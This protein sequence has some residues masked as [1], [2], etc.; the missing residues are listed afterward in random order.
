MTSGSASSPYGELVGFLE[1]VGKDPSRLVFEDELT[2]IHNRRFLRSYLK[3]KVRWDSDKDFPLSLLMIDLDK[4]KEINDTHGHDTGDQVLTYMAALLKDVVGD[5]G[6][7]I[8]FGGDE[9]VLL[10]P[11]AKRS[12]AWEMA[13][14]LLQRTWDRPFRLRAGGIILPITMSIGVAA[15]PEDASDSRG[16]FQAADTAL[17]HAKQSGRNQAASAGAIDLT[18]VF[19]KTAL[20]RLI[21]SGIHGREEE[22]AAVS[23]ALQA[24]SQGQSQF[25]IVDGAPGMGKTAFLDTVR[26]N[27]TSNQALYIAKVV[28]DQKEAYRPYYLATR[29][30]VALLN[31]RK[32]KGTGIL[33]GLGSQEISYLS[34]ILPQLTEGETAPPAEDDSAT[35]QGIFATLAQFLPRIVDSR[36][37]VL[38]IDD[39]QFADEASLLL[40]RTLLQREG[41]ALFVCGSTLEFLKLSADQEAP[42]LER[43]YS[44]R[45]AELGIRRVKLKPLGGDDIAEYLRGVFPSLQMPDGFETDLA[46]LTQ[47]NPLFLGEI[48]RNLV[49][50]RKV[51]LV[52]QQWVIEPLEEGYLPRSLDEIVMQK[53]AALDEEGRQL[54]ERASTLGEDIPVSVLTGSSELDENKVLEFLDRA[55]ALGLISLDFDV[56]DETMRF[57]GKRVMEISYG[58][59]DEDRRKKLHE[60]VGSYQEGLYQQRILPSAS[61]L[62]Y[63]FKRSANQE[64]AR[65]Y[66]QIQLSYTKTVFNPQEAVEYTGDIIEEE[67]ETERRIEPESL[68]LVPNLLRTLMKAV[69]SIQLYPEESRGVV[70]SLEDLKQTVDEILEKNERLHLS[71]AQRV[72]LVNGQRLDVSEV[73]A[74]A[75]AFLELLNRYQ[76]QG[77]TFQQGLTDGEIK[78]LLPTLIKLKPETIDQGFWKTFAAEHGLEQ[79]ELQQMRY[80]RIVRRKVRASAVARAIA[81]EQEL[82]ADELAKIPNVLRAFQGA[83]KTVK[84]YPMGS[85]PVSRAVEQLHG[86]L[87]GILIRHQVLTLAGAE[88]TLLVN[89]ARVDTKGFDG[90]AANLLAFFHSV[91]LTSVTF[92]SNVTPQ[93][94]ETFAGALHA[95]PAAGSE[96][97]F[98]DSFAAEKG[99]TGLAFNQRKYAVGMVQSL[100]GSV[101]VELTEDAAEADAVVELAEQMPEEPADLWEALPR[102]GKELLV[103]GE[104]KLVHQLLQRLFEGYKDQDTPS[105]EQTMHACRALMDGLILGL[106][107]K[108]AELSVESL[109]KA[110]AEETEPQVLRELGALLYAMSGSAVQFANFQLASRMLLELKTRRQQL[111]DTGGR[112]ATSLAALLDRKLSPA[113][114]QLLVDDLSSG[115]P[116]RHQRAAQVI[117][118]LGPSSI[119]LLI[120]VIKQEKDLRIRQMAASLLAEEGPDAA[121]Q[122]KRALTT[123][124]IHEPRARI[125]E[126]IDSV[127]R[128]LKDELAYSLGEDNAR[129][130]RAAFRLFERLQREDFIELVL[131]FTRD[132]DQAAARGAIRS[133]GSL[134]SPRAAEALVSIVKQTEDSKIVIACCQALGQVGDAAGIDALANVLGDRKFPSFARRWDEQVRATAAMALRQ[135]THPQAA[136]VLSGYTNDKDSRIRQLAQSATSGEKAL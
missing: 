105:R 52:G 1:H 93:E 58:A 112:D 5:R 118:S 32:D 80:S 132:K 26:R 91:G 87:Q 73:T 119:P 71:H 3:H 50:D 114:Q 20:N 56:N 76:L 40:L 6:I 136:E 19:P 64:K 90:L 9:F 65:Q 123:E 27:L 110:L 14:R 103:K 70:Q 57:L 115:E 133:L 51:N 124:V 2:G 82:E 81:E 107:H 75:D 54:L 125:L 10:L 117:G 74:V 94:L 83:A 116:E 34:R 8:R 7:P 41:F 100:L 135:I 21:A 25:V 15:A 16:L 129:I 24:L 131:P 72:L 44:A 33:Q 49:A 66:E 84:L 12:D 67:V 17:Y 4:F 36:P 48:I 128:D 92:L 42:P 127:T 28:G 109:L 11:K 46:R 95:P 43:F 47:G 79:I 30:V 69:R 35:R 77:I 102:F 120:E 78:T 59:I 68:P 23:E 55:E 134:R 13:D 88:Q 108:F 53:I 98:W 104:H 122:I 113:V 29:I 38:I 60:Q 121:K 45:Q 86:A 89:G 63:H 97:E 62:A 85:E 99:L 18:K 111:Q 37:L 130:R 106:Q 31:Q 96:T 101:E 22:L 39:L 126:V 61:L